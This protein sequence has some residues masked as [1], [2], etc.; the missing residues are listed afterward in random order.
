MRFSRL[1]T[2]ALLTGTLSLGSCT[3]YQKL[4]KSG[5]VNE[6]YEAAIKYYDKGD[7]F[8]S[9]TLLEELIPL[10]KGRPEA[11]KAQF[12]FANTNYKQRN[13]VLSAYYFKQ[14]IDTYPNSPQ[15][16]EASFLRAKSLYRDSPGFEL[17]QTNTVTAVET[18][19]DFLNTYATSQFRAEAESMSQEL[20]KK[21]ENKAF[22][23]AKLYYALRYNQAAVTSLGNFTVQ[24]PGSVYSEQADYIRLQAQYAWAKESIEAKQRER[25]LDVVAFY[26]HFVDTYPQSKNL[27][28][29]QTMYDDSRTELE[30]LKSI[31][32]ANAAA[33]PAPAPATN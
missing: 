21:L 26:Q 19:Q 2:A 10:L 9:G 7:F 8:R 27:R 14:F 30:R 29:A 3:G 4:L 12:Y 5:S 11:E 20:Q 33:T 16:E 25:F 22:Q 17:D 6:K 13:Y 23:S 28:L 15:V 32:D 1:I 31:P 24:Y 18:I